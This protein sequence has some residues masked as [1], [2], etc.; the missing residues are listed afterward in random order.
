[1][2]I[3]NYEQKY[4]KYKAKYQELKNSLKNNP[5][6]FVGGHGYNTPPENTLKRNTPPENRLKRN[7]PPENTLKRNTPQENNLKNNPEVFVG[8]HGYTPQENN[9]KNNP[10]G[11]VGGHGYT[12]QDNTYSYSSSDLDTSNSEDFY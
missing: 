12:P 9:L 10:E 4:L 5:E 11:F 2:E 6:G 8:G 1:M 7:T 3:E